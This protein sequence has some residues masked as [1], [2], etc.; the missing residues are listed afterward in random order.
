MGE[1][2]STI[3][4]EANALIRMLESSGLNSKLK[5]WT[6]SL[7][8]MSQNLTWGME[9]SLSSVLLCCASFTSKGT[10]VN[11]YLMIS[12]IQLAMKCQR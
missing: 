3:N 12:K 5:V 6:G 2:A 11:F 8:H 1:I 10:E 4:P 9:D 7:L